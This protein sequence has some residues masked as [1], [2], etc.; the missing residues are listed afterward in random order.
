SLE[1]TW[2]SPQSPQAASFKKLLIITVAGEELVQIAFQDQMASAL[3]ARG[4]KAV[5]S[6]RYFTQYTESE[7]AR[8][9]KSIEES[10]ADFVLLSRVTRSQRN[11]REEDR[12]MTIGDATGIYTAYDRYISVA[13]KSGGDYSVKTATVETSIFAM[14][15]DKMVWS[16]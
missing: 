12:F 16:A 8:F 5:A 1:M 3:Q 13:A 4:V 2:V 6:K 11:D 14:Q 10:G 7:K 9:R 15:G